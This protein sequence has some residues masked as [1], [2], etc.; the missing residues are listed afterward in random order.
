MVYALFLLL[1]ILF[2]SQISLR[3]FG[4]S[5]DSSSNFYGSLQNEFFAKSTYEIAKACLKKYDFDYCKEDAITFGDFQSSYEI[6]DEK[7]FYRIEIVLL[8][9]NPRNLHIIRNL[10]NKRIKK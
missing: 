3:Y 9:T 2:V 7:D 4:T 10:I 1:A 6:F 5:L 8:H